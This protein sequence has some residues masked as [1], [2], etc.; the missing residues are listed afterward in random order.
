MKTIASFVIGV[1]VILVVAIPAEAQY[2]R[3]YDPG[4]YYRAAAI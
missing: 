1:F 4:G 3:G 2:R